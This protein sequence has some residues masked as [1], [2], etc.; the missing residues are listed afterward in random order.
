ML[1]EL[2]INVSHTRGRSLLMLHIHSILLGALITATLV[3]D[4]SPVHKGLDQHNLINIH[5]W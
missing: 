5:I 2:L 3:Q 4:I 1:P